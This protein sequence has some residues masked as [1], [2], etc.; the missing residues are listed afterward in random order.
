MPYTEC[1]IWKQAQVGT[2]LYMS[3]EQTRPGELAGPETDIWS[4]GVVM[5]VMLTG[6]KPF[7]HGNE[8]DRIAIGQAIR[9]AAPRDPRDITEVGEVDDGVAEARRTTQCNTMRRNATPCNAMQRNAMQRM[10]T[11]MCTLRLYFRR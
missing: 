7:G 1:S 6:Q 10:R 11:R 5:Y 9:D 8:D 4:M 3:P 2:P